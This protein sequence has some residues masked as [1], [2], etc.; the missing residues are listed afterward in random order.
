MF[1]CFKICSSYEKCH[2]E[3]VYLK[4]PFKCNRYSNG[5][6]YTCIKFFLRNFRSPKENFQA[7]RKS[8]YC[9]FSHFWVI[10][11]KKRNRLNSCI[12]NHLP[13]WTL[14]N[15]FQSK[16]RLDQDF[17]FRETILKNVFSENLENTFWYTFKKNT[18]IS[19]FDKTL[20]CS[21]SL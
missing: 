4:E 18:D 5:F 2:N 7:V 11:F 6:V 17:E 8:N 12:R 14:K 20:D 21:S 19:C 3:I 9:S 13:S 15:A 16:T 10:F 1:R